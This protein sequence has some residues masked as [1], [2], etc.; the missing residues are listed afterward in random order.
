MPEAFVWFHNSSSKPNESKSFYEK[1]LGWA[2]SDGPGGMTLFASEK[3]PFAGLDG[4]DGDLGGAQIAR[5]QRA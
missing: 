3:R 4:K 2:A 1:L 5:W